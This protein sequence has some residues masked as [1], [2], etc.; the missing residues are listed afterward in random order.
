MP[1]QSI[2]QAGDDIPKIALAVGNYDDIQDTLAKLGLGEV[3]S[4]GAL[5]PGEAPGAGVASFCVRESSNDQVNAAD[6]FDYAFSTAV[7]VRLR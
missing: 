4:N 3:G 5:V 2:P 1:G 7:I 6:A